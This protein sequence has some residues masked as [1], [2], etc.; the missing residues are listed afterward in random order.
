MN[1]RKKLGKIEPEHF[2]YRGKE[3]VNLRAL[4]KV[5]ALTDIRSQIIEGGDLRSRYVADVLRRLEEI[6]TDAA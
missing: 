4:E 6:R 3:K 2:I 5:D 1:A